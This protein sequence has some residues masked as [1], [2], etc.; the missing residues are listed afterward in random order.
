MDD[1]PFSLPIDGAAELAALLERSGVAFER[2]GE[3]FRFLFTSRGCKWQT[4]CD[5]RESRVLVYG[6]HPARV[7]AEAEALAL[8]SQLNRQ[9]VRGSLFLQEE[10]F[11]FRT[12]AELTELFEAQDELARALEYNAA[13][14]SAYWE[15]LAA[16][17]QGLALTF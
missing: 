14:L 16:G 15:R 12:G 17:A 9:L 5:C 6:I 2:E 7:T 8:C 3:R 11:I 1:T 10:R 13:V 4:V